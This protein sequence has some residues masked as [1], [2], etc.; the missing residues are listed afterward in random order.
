MA[1]PA[2]L[3]WSAMSLEHT[4]ANVVKRLGPHDDLFQL[5]PDL[6]GLPPRS[7]EAQVARMRRLLAETRLRAERNIARQVEATAR[8]RARVAAHHR[9]RR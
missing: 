2:N 5:F 9:R 6:P 3:F 1:V 7:R 8:V 4:L